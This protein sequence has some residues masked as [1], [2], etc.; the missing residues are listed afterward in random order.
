MKKEMSATEK[1]NTLTA[2]FYNMN[3]ITGF[4][5]LSLVPEFLLFSRT[6]DSLITNEQEEFCCLSNNK[7][8][9][10]FYTLFKITYFRMFMES[11]FLEN[12]IFIKDQ[13][14]WDIKSI[15]NSI[16]HNLTNTLAT[17]GGCDDRLYSSP[18]MVFRDDER[19]YSEYT[20]YIQDLV[21]I[22]T[23]KLDSR[24]LD[25]VQ[26]YMLGIENINN[27]TKPNVLVIDNAL[28]NLNNCILNLKNKIYEFK[29]S[30]NFKSDIDVFP[31]RWEDNLIL[32][33]TVGEYDYEIVNESSYFLNLTLGFTIKE[34]NDEK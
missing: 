12:K 14:V 30:N 5:I 34:T 26:D 7:T 32:V 11:M 3:I 9:T 8:P 13:I 33:E 10:S 24:F 29:I 28:N 27:Y 18:F 2:E 23:Y 4:G 6:I 16:F 22:L 15:F 31:Y 1:C 25:E 21:L 17:V 20:S 19:L